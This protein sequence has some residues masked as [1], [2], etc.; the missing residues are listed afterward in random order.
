MINAVSALL[1]FV[2]L[3][4][5]MKRIEP[6]L[7]WRTMPLVPVVCSLYVSMQPSASLALLAFSFCAAK[8]MDYSFRAVVNEMVSEY[9]VFAVGSLVPY[10]S[11]GF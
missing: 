3:P 5:T 9:V 2:V 1:Q 7:L 10:D 4:L 6:K 11:P 8:C